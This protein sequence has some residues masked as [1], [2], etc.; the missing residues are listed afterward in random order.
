[1]G[2]DGPVKVQAWIQLENCDRSWKSNIHI[3]SCKNLKQQKV[4]MASCGKYVMVPWS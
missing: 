2:Y 1:M 4:I 3:L